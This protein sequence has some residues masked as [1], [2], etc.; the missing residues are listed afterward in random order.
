MEK[1]RWS[2]IRAVVIAAL[3]TIVLM[4][5]WHQHKF[6]G[7]LSGQCGIYVFVRFKYP[8]AQ[9]WTTAQRL[10]PFKSERFANRVA[11]DFQAYAVS[12]DSVKIEILED[13]PQY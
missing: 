10:G 13:C 2:V 4:D 11:A 6:R 1:I 3:I 8:D 12:G 9:L 7:L 5:Q